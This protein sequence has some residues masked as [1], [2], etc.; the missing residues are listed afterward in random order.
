MRSRPTAR[1]RRMAFCLALAGSIA[2]AVEPDLPRV[3]GPRPSLTLSFVGDIMHHLVNAEMPDYDRLYDAVRDVLA[4][5]DLSFANIEFPVDPAQEPAGFP[6][7]NGSV[8]YIEAAI[9][10]GFDVF[11]LANNHTYDL[12]PAG[13]AATRE[14]FRDLEARAAIF[15]NGIRSERGA[16]LAATEIVYRGWRIGFVSITSFS[17]V[18]GSGPYINL[19]DYLNPTARSRFLDRVR[20][21]SEEFDLLIISVHAGS[22]YVLSPVGHKVEF[23]REL[24][25]AGAAVV[26]GHHPHV[27]QPWEHRNGG[28]IIYSAGNFISAQRR[29]QSPYVPFGRWAPTGDTAIF[30]VRVEDRQ[31]G[32]ESRLVRIPAFT[33][34]L[35]PEHGLVL[36]TFDEVIAGEL[37]LPWRAFYLARYAFMRRFAATEAFRELDLVR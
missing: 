30:Q 16:E 5:D 4:V 17:N 8:A 26:W 6:V 13:V 37:S 27:L 29:H 33:K 22:E 2:L 34:Y 31:G 25:D 14:V 9:R 19:V 11:A 7:F 35:D 20:S 32:V 12:G 3:D 15:T 10:G 23:F 28:V 24:S 18:W 21:W 36:R 1:A